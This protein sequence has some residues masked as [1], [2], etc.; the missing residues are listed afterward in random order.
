[1]AKNSVDTI[2]WTDDEGVE[3]ELPA[4]Y[5]VCSRCEGFGTHLNPNIGEHAYTQ[6]EFLD[7]FD[8]EEQE[9]Y[10]TRGGMY[11]VTCE[12]CRGKRVVLVVDGD[13]C[14]NGLYEAYTKDMDAQA[15]MD[16][17]DEMTRRAEN[18]EW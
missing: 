15:Q 3:H 16:Y 2:A 11:D 17:E 7:E 10:F 8:D 5:E 18:G 14:K 6:E 13:K 1:M 4:K 9:A 12:E